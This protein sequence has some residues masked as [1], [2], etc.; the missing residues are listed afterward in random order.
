MTTTLKTLIFCAGIGQLSVLVASALVP[1]RL[2]WKRSLTVLPELVR[3]LFWVYGG[4]VVLSIVALGLI[5]LLNSDELA[6]GS[7]LA[8]SFCV[9]AACFWGIRL[10]LQPFLKAKPFLTTWWLSAG[11][12]LLSVLFS[13]FV[14][15]FTWAAFH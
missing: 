4:Y 10:S 11:Y 15:V 5:S 9:Y 8:R 7:T 2:E 1:I 13:S 14:L 12:H 6:N 3:Q